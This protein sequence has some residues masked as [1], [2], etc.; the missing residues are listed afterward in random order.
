MGDPLAAGTDVGPQ[1]RHDLRDALH[2]QVRG[3]IEGGAKLLLGGDDP[4]RRGRLLSTDGAGEREARHARVRR[5]DC[6]DRSRRSSRARDEADAIRIANDSSFGLG[7]AVFTKDIARGERV[8]QRTRGGRDVRQQPGRLG[9]AAAVRR[10]QGIRLRPRARCLRHQ[11]IRQC[12]DGG[13]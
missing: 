13:R 10:D 4:A 9:S 11:G 3:S 5:G 8:A 1:A 2:K 12:E 7:G 6:S